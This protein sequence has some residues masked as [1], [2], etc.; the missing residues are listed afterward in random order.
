MSVAGQLA[1]TTVSFW[2]MVGCGALAVVWSS[3]ALL[4]PIIVTSLTVW[5]VYRKAQEVRS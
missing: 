3:W 5:D 2:A 4:P 1:F